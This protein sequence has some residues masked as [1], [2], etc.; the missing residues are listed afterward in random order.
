[1]NPKNY[2]PGVLWISVISMLSMDM[3]GSSLTSGMISHF[4]HI[5]GFSMHRVDNID[6]VVR[7]TAHLTVYGILAVLWFR[8]FRKS[9][10]G[11]STALIL[12][13]I[14]SCTCGALDEFHQSFEANRTGKVS[15]VFIDASGATAALIFYALRTKRR[16]TMRADPIS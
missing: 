6:F 12:S 3:F 13:F 15:D 4:I 2:I 1:M 5:F 7:K 8:A 11:F 9:G 16:C 14:I 10:F